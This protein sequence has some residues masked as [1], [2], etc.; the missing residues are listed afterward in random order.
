MCCEVTAKEN[1]DDIS[2]A[3]QNDLCVTQTYLCPGPQLPL[4]GTDITEQTGLLVGNYME[5]CDDV[6]GACFGLVF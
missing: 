4:P 6:K 1:A 3:E 5:F 2:M